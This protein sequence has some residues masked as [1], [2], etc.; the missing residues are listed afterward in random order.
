MKVPVSLC[1]SCQSANL[2]EFDTE[3]AIHF[4]GLKGLDKLPVFSFPKLVVC[5]EC[6]ASR[7]NISAIELRQLKGRAEGVEEVAL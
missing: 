3:M 2:M 1:N 4:P 7:C 6:G 5:L